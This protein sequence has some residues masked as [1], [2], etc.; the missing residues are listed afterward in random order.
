[1]CVCVCVCVAVAVAVAVSVTI[2]RQSHQRMFTSHALQAQ[3]SLEDLLSKSKVNDQ[4]R[5]FLQDKYDKLRHQLGETSV[6]KLRL[7][8]SS[9]KDV[10]VKTALSKRIQ[11][12]ERG[13]EV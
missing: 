11:T 13:V 3:D 2:Y 7:E 10:K 4:V 6:E 8:L 5:A 9:S 1:V 12:L